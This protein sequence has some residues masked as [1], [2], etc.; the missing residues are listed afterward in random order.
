ME[1]RFFTS[2][3]HFSHKKILE[4]C[5]ETRLGDTVDEMD[6]LLIQ[7]WNSKIK[8]KDIV[9]HLG[10]FSFAPQVKTIKIIKRLNGFIHLIEGNHD[11]QL[12]STNCRGLF[13]SKSVYKTVT[14]GDTRCVLM[15]FPISSW[16]RMRYGSLMLHGHQHGGVSNH[17]DTSGIIKNRMDIGVDTRVEKDMAPYHIDEVIKLIKERDA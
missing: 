7:A 12:D 14:I 4:F 13:E 15:H 1:N 17:I 9:Y 11:R 5:R 10:D 6:E 8:P 2:D 3:T 16:D